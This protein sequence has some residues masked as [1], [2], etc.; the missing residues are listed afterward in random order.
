MPSLSPN[1]KSI[2]AVAYKI[3]TAARFISSLTSM[4]RWVVPRC[5]WP[6]SS[7]ITLAEMPEWASLVMKER[8]PLWLDAPSIPALLQ[9][10]PNSWQS[11]LAENGP[12]F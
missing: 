5:L 11:V 12:P 4:Y 6:A 9:S 8:R 10:S 2:N 1:Q 7:M 3:S